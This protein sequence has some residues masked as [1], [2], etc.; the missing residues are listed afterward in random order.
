MKIAITGAS[1]FVGS[2]LVTSLL[3]QNHKLNLLTH[4]KEPSFNQDKNINIF[5]G[6]IHNQDSLQN[7]LKDVD[8]VYHLV[9]IIA[10][11]GTLT[12]KKTVIQGTKNLVVACQKNDVKKIIYLSALGTEKNAPSQYHQSKWQAE[13]AVRK[14]GIDYVILRPSVIY[15]QGDGFVS[16]VKKLIIKLP[17]TPIIG[18][19]DFKLQPIYIDDLIS[20]MTSLLPNRDVL[21][22]TIE[23][24]GPQQLSYLQIVKI[25][26]SILKKKRGTLYLPMWFMKTNAWILERIMKRPPLTTDQ[27]RMMQIGN[28]CDNKKLLKNID[29][30]LTPFEEGLKKYLR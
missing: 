18:R 16:M 22:Q 10:E 7:F 17:L 15:G 24:G 26:K 11:T 8:V 28:I 4:K 30:K 1:G 29:I 20:I 2:Y 14:S 12:F 23:I 27:L 19:G 25:L 5:T 3:N 21:N 13:E 9:G 6:D